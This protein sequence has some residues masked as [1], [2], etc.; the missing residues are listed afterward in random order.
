MYINIILLYLSSPRR[1]IY[2]IY[3]RYTKKKPKGCIYIERES[4]RETGY[5]RPPREDVS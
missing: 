5:R 2:N 4:N 3:Y 1:C